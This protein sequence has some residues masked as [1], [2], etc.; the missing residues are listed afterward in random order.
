MMMISMNTPESRPIPLGFSLVIPAY[1]EA[2]GVGSVLEDVLQVL[3][4]LEMPWEVI[5]VDDGSQDGTAAIV[6]AVAQAH[7][8]LY[9]IRHRRNFGYGAALK[10]GIR[11]ARYALIGITDADGTYP[12]GRIPELVT[13]LL[14]HDADMIIG[15]RVGRGAAI[16]LVRRPAKWV[17]ARLAEVV[18]GE[19]IPD[20]NSGLRVFW[21]STARR[22]FPLLPDGFS[23]TTTITLGMLVNGYLV[24]YLPVDYYARKGQSKINPVKDTLRFV[25]LVLQIALYFSPL[26]IFLPLSFSLFFLALAWAGGTYFVLGRMADASAAMLVMTAIQVAITGL[27]ADLFNRRL[28]GYHKEDSWN[29]GD[30]GEDGSL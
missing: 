3:S 9:L 2:L 10:T 26:K 21:R 29:V 22:F 16:P 17:I 25:Q 15:A 30:G 18:A 27:L 11:R 13:N 4:R 14:E 23:F 5:V 12:N 19:A 6:Q 8:Q 24:E 28:P 7:N 20:L 1:N